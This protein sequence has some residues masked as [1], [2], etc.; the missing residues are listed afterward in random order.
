MKDFK[1]SWKS[2][3]LAYNLINIIVGIVFFNIVPNLLNY[4]PN[5]INND[6]QIAINGLTYTQQYISIFSFGVLA[7]NVIL[8]LVYK[9]LKKT[10][11]NI[12]Q[13]SSEEI[14]DMYL[15]VENKIINTPKLIYVLQV[16][17][18]V[19]MIISTFLMLGGNIDVILKVCL[20][21]FTMFLA[22]STICYTFSKKIF[23]S[24]LINLF[25]MVNENST[26]NIDTLFNKIKRSSIK[27]SI[28][29]A[30]IPIIVILAIFISFISYSNNSNSIGSLLH[31][32]YTNE[33]KKVGVTYSSVNDLIND[34]NKIDLYNEKQ[35]SYFI[36][37]GNETVYSSDNK[38]LSEFFVKYIYDISPTLSVKNKTYDFYA[39]AYQGI[40][41]EVNING[42]QSIVGVRYYT[43]DINMFILI[44]ISSLIIITIAIGLIKYTLNYSFSD[45][46]L[47]TQRLNDIAKEKNVN[48]N[49]KVPIYSNNEISDLSKSF[50]RVQK[51]TADYIEQIQDSQNTLMERE[52]LATLGQM[53]GG[54]AHNLKTPIMS[55]A[56]AMEGMND[57]IDEY[58]KSIDDPDVTKEDHHS[59][60]KDMREWITKVNSYDSYMS[61]IISAVKGQAVNLNDTSVEEF[62]IDELL[63]RVNILMK[64][65]LKNSLTVLNTNCTISENTTLKGNV[66]S[67]VQIVNN[68]ISNAIQAYNNDNNQTNKMIN[69]TI[70]EKDNN[71]IISVEDFGCG[72]PEEVQQKLFKSMITTKGHNGTGLGLFMSYSNIKGHFNGDLNFTSEVGK[73]TKFNIILPKQI[74]GSEE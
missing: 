57:L 66:N 51:R 72:I 52:R 71:I 53:V 31:D 19:V 26:D 32:Y 37:K 4:P 48:L 44:F 39:T 13:A 47:I 40:F 27:T 28:I 22:I 1:K 56:G 11:I 17:A 34:L 7:E 35:D 10:L 8:F 29:L 60:A 23:K 65:E 5:S 15:K 54:I 70:S 69:L 18:P 9:R 12:D 6:F 45:V 55:I 36:L 3:L 16:T 58:E 46:K 41:Y 38:D 42:V 74:T 50:N 62:T 73:G 63:K 68:L 30:F 33:F 20:V 25:Y 67:L 61:D 2:L 43:S 14:K 59:I 49:N 21:F 64:H 24:I